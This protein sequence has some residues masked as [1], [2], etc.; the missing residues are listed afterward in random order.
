ML[1]FIILLSTLFL[2]F[3]QIFAGPSIA[4]IQAAASQ[5]I[6]NTVVPQATMG[7]PESQSTPQ[8]SLIT[9]SSTTTPVALFT[10][11]YQTTPV[12]TPASATSIIEQPK[13]FTQSDLDRAKQEAL[14][15]AKQEIL[16]QLSNMHSQI[17]AP[18]TPVIPTNTITQPIPTMQPLIPMITQPIQNSQPQLMIPTVATATQNSPGVATI[19]SI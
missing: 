9:N 7:A 3:S 14:E 19:P 8:T 16:K 4:D 5:P 18:Q 1:N 11:N 17:T 15:Q 6:I 13:I 10:G 2:G 12:A